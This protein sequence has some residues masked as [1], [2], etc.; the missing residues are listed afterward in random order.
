VRD[1]LVR[2]REEMASEALCRARTLEQIG[3]KVAHELKNPLAAI[4]A[5]VQLSARNAPAT[6]S[7]ERLQVVEKEVSRMQDI[8]ADYLSFTRPLQEVRPEQ[9]ELGSLV[10]EALSVLSARADDAR[11]TL[12]S[13]GEAT[14]E[15]DPRRIREAVL[16]LV[17][18]AIEASQHGGDV[19]VEVLGRGESAEIVVRDSGSGM[20]PEALKRLGTPF[21]TTRDDGT[22]LGVVLA[23]S[24]VAQ[25]GGSLRYDSELGRGTTASIS[26]PTRQAPRCHDGARTA[27]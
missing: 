6:L 18:N 20:P 8:L 27:R 9:I 12:S 11:V 26:L 24:V 3:A 2:A 13:R 7:Q 14:V 15:A 19:T 21:F 5:L 16:N 22:G 4:K 1:A 17:A 23:R 25:H 10:S